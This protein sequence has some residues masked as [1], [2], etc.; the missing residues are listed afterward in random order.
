MKEMKKKKKMK[1]NERHKAEKICQK[2]RFFVL[3]VDFRTRAVV[4]KAIFVAI[5]YP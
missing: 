5:C 2:S 3:C 1:S 4:A